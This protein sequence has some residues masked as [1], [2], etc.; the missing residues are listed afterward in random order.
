MFFMV[1]AFGV[2]HLAMEKKV[3]PSAF[4]RTS[5]DERNTRNMQ[6]AHRYFCPDQLFGMLS[7]WRRLAMACLCDAS[8]PPV[9]VWHATVVAILIVGVPGAAICDFLISLSVT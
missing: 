1:V 3:S 8:L 6:L 2:L 9:V 5:C 4:E 7:F